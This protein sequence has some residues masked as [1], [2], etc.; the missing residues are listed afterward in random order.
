MIS[1]CRPFGTVPYQ[2][3]L[4]AERIEFVTFHQS[5]SYEEFVEGLR[6]ET[7]GAEGQELDADELDTAGFRLKVEDGVFKRICERARLDPGKDS[8]DRRLDRA[9][10]IFKIALGRRLQEEA[11]IKEALDTNEIHHGWSGT[12]NWSDER[13]EDWAAIKTELEKEEIS[14][15]VG[16]LVCTYSFRSDMQMGDYIVV[17]Y[18]RDIMRVFGMIASD[19]FFKADAE[20][21]PHR[22]RVEWLWRDDQGTERARFYPNGFRQHTVYKL[23]GALVDWDGLE[24]LIFGVDRS[25]LAESALSHILIIDEINRAN[26]S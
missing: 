15:R 10:P 8:G 13:F 12:I 23:N 19:Y 5:M 6:P 2:R 20:H 11:Q 22:R 3:L 9:R 18:G 21:H 24:E 25:I 4:A 26:I 17:S 1:R 7:Q 14:G 16:E